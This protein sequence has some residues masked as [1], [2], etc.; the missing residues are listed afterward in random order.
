MTPL[1]HNE[2]ANNAQLS[3]LDALEA[4]YAAPEDAELADDEFA[5]AAAEAIGLPDG[6]MPEEPQP[7]DPEK[8]EDGE[9]EPH[10]MTERI[11][12]RY[13]SLRQ[14]AQTFS[15]HVDA[16]VGKMNRWAWSFEDI[17]NAINEAESLKQDGSITRSAWTLTNKEADKR[18]RHHVGRE[19]LLEALRK[20][21]SLQARVKIKNKYPGIPY[22][23][24]GKRNLKVKNQMMKGKR[25]LGKVTSYKFKDN[26]IAKE[27]NTIREEHMQISDSKSKGASINTIIN[28]AEKK[29]NKAISHM[30]DRAE[31]L[32]KKRL[33]EQKNVV[34]DGEKITLEWINGLKQAIDALK[35]NDRDWF[36]LLRTKYYAAI[37]A[38]DTKIASIQSQQQQMQTQFNRSAETETNTAISYLDSMKRKVEN[39][40]KPSL[41]LKERRMELGSPELAKE[42]SDFLSMPDSFP[43]A[44]QLFSALQQWRTINDKLMSMYDSAQPSHPIFTQ[45]RIDR[46]GL[47][48]FETKMATMIDKTIR[49]I[50]ERA[51][52]QVDTR[53][54]TPEQS[55]YAMGLNNTIDRGTAYDGALLYLKR[56]GTLSWLDQTS[57]PLYQETIDQRNETRRNAAG[58]VITNIRTYNRNLTTSIDQA[59]SAGNQETL[60]SIVDNAA[61]LLNAFREGK[62]K[63][64]DMVAAGA[65]VY[66]E[67]VDTRGWTVLKMNSTEIGGDITNSTY[68]QIST[69]LRLNKPNK[70]YE[71]V[72]VAEL[73]RIMSAQAKWV[74]YSNYVVINTNPDS[75]M[76]WQIDR[77][78]EALE[79]LEFGTWKNSTDV[80][81]TQWNQLL[82]QQIALAQTYEA[83]LTNPTDAATFKEARNAYLKN[84]NDQLALYTNLT[85]HYTGWI[86]EHRWSYQSLKQLNNDGNNYLEIRAD[87]DKDGMLQFGRQ[88]GS[89]QLEQFNKLGGSN[90]R[91]SKAL[92]L[93]NTIQWRE[94][95]EFGFIYN[96][97]IAY[98]LYD[99]ASDVIEWID[100][101]SG[102]ITPDQILQ[103]HDAYQQLQYARTRL[104]GTKRRW[105]TIP[106]AIHYAAKLEERQ[107]SQEAQALLWSVEQLSELANIDNLWKNTYNSM[108]KEASSIYADIV[109]Q[110]SDEYLTLDKREEIKQQLHEQQAKYQNQVSIIAEKAQPQNEK[111][112]PQYERMMEKFNKIPERFD[113]LLEQWDKIEALIVRK[114][115]ENVTERLSGSMNKTLASMM[116]LDP[117]VGDNKDDFDRKMA[118]LHN[119]LDKAKA[120]LDSTKGKPDTESSWEEA[121]KVYQDLKKQLTSLTADDGAISIDGITYNKSDLDTKRDSLPEWGVEAGHK[122]V[123]LLNLDESPLDF[124]IDTNTKPVGGKQDAILASQKVEVMEAELSRESQV[125]TYMNEHPEVTDELNTIISAI[126]SSWASLEG[127]DV[128]LISSTNPV[129]NEF[130][131]QLGTMHDDISISEAKLSE[132]DDGSNFVLALN[133]VENTTE[134]PTERTL[135]LTIGKDNPISLPVSRNVDKKSEENAK[136]IRQTEGEIITHSET[137]DDATNSVQEWITLSIDEEWLRVHNFV[138]SASNTGNFETTKEYILNEEYPSNYLQSYNLRQEQIGQ[139]ITT[140]EGNSTFRFNWYTLPTHQIPATPQTVQAMVQEK[141][142]AWDTTGM[143]DILNTY[144]FARGRWMDLQ[145]KALIPIFEKI[146]MSLEAGAAPMII[147]G[148][149][150]V[151]EWKKTDDKTELTTSEAKNLL[152][153]LNP[154]SINYDPNNSD[155]TARGATFEV[156]DY[157]PPEELAR[158]IEADIEQPKDSLQI[159]LDGYHFY[160]WSIKELDNKASTKALQ[161]LINGTDEALARNYDIRIF[162]TWHYM[163]GWEQSVINERYSRWQDIA[164]KSSLGN[165]EIDKQVFAVKDGKLALKPELL[166]RFFDYASRATISNRKDYAT[167]YPEDKQ[168]HHELTSEVHTVFDKDQIKNLYLQVMKMDIH[169]ML[170]QLDIPW[171]AWMDESYVR[172][173]YFFLKLGRTSYDMHPNALSYNRALQAMSQYMKH[174]MP[175]KYAEAMRKSGAVS[176][177]DIAE[178]FYKNVRLWPDSPYKHIKMIVKWYGTYNM[179]WDSERSKTNPPQAIST[180]KRVAVQMLTKKRG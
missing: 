66:D 168:W 134:W 2:A 117:R 119:L 65:T 97:K 148:M 51:L 172:K 35:D 157:D 44:T 38:I 123:S 141:I 54:Y 57:V 143:K 33:V 110:M 145:R 16:L 179:Q 140:D 58:T 175:I 149:K 155:A 9:R 69:R 87:M 4:E 131:K 106:G 76:A 150:V 118:H 116:R 100:F 126:T 55:N 176:E 167:T 163:T 75:T 147:Y 89:T 17:M 153:Q 12:N 11:A 146:D 108:S 6:E 40:I 13:T 30:A 169:D 144:L 7:G 27:L 8:P 162:F 90:N 142:D 56:A 61:P 22:E 109:N 59:I 128:N 84:I 111:D 137:V 101:T 124:T 94:A 158:P 178:D 156:V 3:D 21:R 31:N 73:S 18:H 39:T 115:L 85:D 46:E 132:T 80:M 37:D 130:I 68:S 72:S 103:V 151:P 164:T 53:T 136:N 135:K 113:E 129:V 29:L 47:T 25:N 160:A 127:A 105:K 34:V 19:N 10:Y 93:L 107:K 121:N 99:Q 96:M 70:W 138:G 1:Q 95:R 45:N 60:Q 92:M 74:D 174:Y 112:R 120:V 24:G 170:D 23:A 125:N 83:E 48:T 159:N 41:D 86:D 67:L 62:I 49:P 88:L 79:W 171:L 71:N 52:T 98:D 36:S 104:V 102:K 15:Q 50:K 5:D 20:S 166:N 139:Y 64:R 91:M 63:S 122:K 133:Y 43:S 180:Q 77:A 173:Q 152:I 26:D 161:E 82:E 154:L 114:W 42:I 177:A 32:Y 28:A 14:D 165:A 81:V 78:R